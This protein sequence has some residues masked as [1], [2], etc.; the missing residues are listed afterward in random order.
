MTRNSV[1]SWVMIVPVRGLPWSRASSPK[2]WPPV[3]T[4]TYWPYLEVMSRPEE[5]SAASFSAF[6]ALD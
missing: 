5:A 1:S 3:R 6:S 4:L 2:L